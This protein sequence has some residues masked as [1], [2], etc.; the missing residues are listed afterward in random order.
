MLAD[1]RKN[2]DID[3]KKIFIGYYYGTV[4]RMKATSTIEEETRKGILKNRVGN[5][6]DD[7]IGYGL[8]HLDVETIFM[9]NCCPITPNLPI[10]VICAAKDENFV[11]LARIFALVSLG[12]QISAPKD[13]PKGL[14]RLRTPSALCNLWTKRLLIFLDLTK[15][16]WQ[17]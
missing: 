10:C 5:I 11:F 6:S 2:P 9:R 4:L 8:D 16:T 3:I 1:N 12:A 15:Y 17:V 14:L 7:T 13:G